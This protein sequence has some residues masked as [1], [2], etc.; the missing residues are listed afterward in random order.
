M[1]GSGVVL[2]NFKVFKGFIEY[3]EWLWGQFHLPGLTIQRKGFLLERV[4]HV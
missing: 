4:D 3:I 2:M 1:V